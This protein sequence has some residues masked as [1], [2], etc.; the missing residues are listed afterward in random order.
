MA[1]ARPGAR[2]LHVLKPMQTLM[3]EQLRLSS[4]TCMTSTLARCCSVLDKHA[5]PASR[6]RGRVPTEIRDGRHF[7]EDMRV[8]KHFVWFCC[9]HPCSVHTSTQT[10]CPILPASD[11]SMYDNNA[12]AC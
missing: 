2:D 9:A 8:A 1:V 6:S 10:T 4:A 3:F 5:L 11:T 7:G 12:C